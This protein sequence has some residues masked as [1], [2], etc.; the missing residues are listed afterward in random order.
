MIYAL[1]DGAEAN[2]AMKQSK[3]VRSTPPWGTKDRAPCEQGN[4]DMPARH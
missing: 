3:D 2:T 4:V 1:Q